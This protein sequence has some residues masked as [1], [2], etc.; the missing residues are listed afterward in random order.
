MANN[1]CIGF[2]MRNQ[3]LFQELKKIGI[4]FSDDGR[5]CNLTTGE[6]YEFCFEDGD[7]TP[8]LGFNHDYMIN[9]YLEYFLGCGNP[10]FNYQFMKILTEND[11]FESDY[12]F[13]NNPFDKNQYYDYDFFKQFHPTKKLTDFDS[14]IEEA[15]VESVEFD[16][17]VTAFH[18]AVT[19][20]IMTISDLQFEIEDDFFFDISEFWDEMDEETKNEFSIQKTFKNGQWV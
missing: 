7:N 6:A 19:D 10:K 4:N 9:I 18:A 16:G 2:C 20:G 3:K 17:E 11:Y 12:D 15:Y 14:S 13:K 1:S 5:E 8:Y